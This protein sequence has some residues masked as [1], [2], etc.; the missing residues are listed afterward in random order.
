MCENQ[1]AFWIR[2][3]QTVWREQH[4]QGDSSNKADGGVERLFVNQFWFK[5]PDHMKNQPFLLLK[6]KHGVVAD[7]KD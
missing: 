1:S 4:T 5:E 2:Q 6:N 3:I 7:I